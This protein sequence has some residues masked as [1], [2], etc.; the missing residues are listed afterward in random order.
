[1]EYDTSEKAPLIQVTAAIVNAPDLDRARKI[2]L[3]ICDLL[4]CGSSYG[5]DLSMP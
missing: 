4:A 1:M 3:D 5:G 2:M